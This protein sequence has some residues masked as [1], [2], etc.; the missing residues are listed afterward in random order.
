MCRSQ[1]ICSVK[2]TLSFFNWNAAMYGAQGHAAGLQT[3]AH[4]SASSLP[5]L[6]KSGTSFHLRISSETVLFHSCSTSCTNCSENRSQRSSSISIASSRSRLPAANGFLSG[7]QSSLLGCSS[8]RKHVALPF[9]LSTR[10]SVGQRLR[11]IKESS[12]T[13]ATTDETTDSR[14]DVTRRV[15]AADAVPVNEEDTQSKVR[16]CIFW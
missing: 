10:R 1:S 7:A 4:H 9:S 6:P 2:A 5:T 16:L 15:I 11:S 8:L 14:P 12:F 13:E 3:A